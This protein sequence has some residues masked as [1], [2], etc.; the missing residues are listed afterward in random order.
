MWIIMPSLPTFLFALLFY[1]FTFYFLFYLHPSLLWPKIQ[2]PKLPN[3][4][5]QVLQG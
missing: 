4:S 5:I 1:Y 2:G 3:Y